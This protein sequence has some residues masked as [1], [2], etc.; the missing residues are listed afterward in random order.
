VTLE[1]IKERIAK[2]MGWSRK[3]VDSFSLPTMR[4]FVRGKDEELDKA[5]LD[6]IETKSHLFTPIDEE[7]PWDP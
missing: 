6:V 3:E 1:Q 7:G 2:V 4:E 5:L